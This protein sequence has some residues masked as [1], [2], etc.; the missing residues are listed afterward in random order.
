MASYTVSERDMLITI[1]AVLESEDEITLANIMK[2]SKFVFNP[3]WEFSYVLPDQKKLYA[4]L[5]V[6]VNYKKYI[7][8]NLVKISDIAIDIYNDDEDYRFLG[9]NDVVITSYSIHYTKLYDKSNEANT[10]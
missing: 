9:I 5:K 3:Q 7:K 10:V 2:V 6:P 1:V 4:T 8:D